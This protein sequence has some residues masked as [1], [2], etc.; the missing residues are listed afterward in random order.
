MQTFR[1]PTPST[2]LSSAPNH[3]KYAL[4]RKSGA[5]HW[6]PDEE[7]DQNMG[8]VD[9]SHHNNSYGVV[10]VVIQ[11]EVSLVNNRTFRMLPSGF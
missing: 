9:H 6:R 11:T 7:K 8:A 10:L 3:K 1:V 5:K 2:N 4:H